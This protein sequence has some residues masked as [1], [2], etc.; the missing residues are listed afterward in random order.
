M[1][2]HRRADVAA[3]TADVTWWVETGTET[4]TGAWVVGRKRKLTAAAA[5]AAVAAA[6]GFFLVGAGLGKAGVAP[7][8][9]YRAPGFTLESSAGKPLSLAHLKGKPVFL[10]F[11]ASW[12]PPCRTE[13]PDLVKM[14]RRFGK[15]IDF[16][17]I[18]LTGSDSVPAVRAF[19]RRYG[20][21]YPVLFDARDKVAKRYA[22]FGLPT[23]LF[24]NRSGIIADRVTGKMDTSMMVRYFTHLLAQ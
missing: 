16:V 2:V 15:Q 9:G 12:C 17:S 23:S 11:W 8:V 20:V 7:Q 21:P 14:Y 19:I 6:A 13:T 22:V 1:I 10:N 5:S 18:D 24:V 3:G 4:E